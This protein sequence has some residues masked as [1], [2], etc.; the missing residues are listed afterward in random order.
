MI[1]NPRI[2]AKRDVKTLEFTAEKNKTKERKLAEVLLSPT[3]LNAITAQTFIQPI[4]GDFD[5]TE[6][7]SVIQEKSENIID[8][9]LSELESTLTAQVVSLNAIF[10]TLARRS[11]ANMGGNLKA[12]EI[13]MRLALKAQSQSARTIEV[14]TTLKNPPVVY[15]KQA[16]ISHGH[17]QVNNGINQPTYA[18]ETIN[19]ENELLSEINHETLD[20]R[21]TIKTSGIN[22]DM[23]AVEALNGSKDGERQG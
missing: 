21:G 1:M 8:G 10:N 17:Q 9:D 13:Y 16:N 20:T 2:P 3:N 6:A 23:A 4:A 22:Q 19:S 15:A 14:L 18:G 12:V 11:A 5:L 7:V